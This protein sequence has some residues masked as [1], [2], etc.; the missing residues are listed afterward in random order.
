VWT[1]RLVNLEA[2]ARY[3]DLALAQLLGDAPEAHRIAAR[4]LTELA[5]VVAQQ[6]GGHSHSTVRPR[7]RHGAPRHAARTKPLLLALHV[8]ALAVVA[9]TTFMLTTWLSALK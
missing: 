4:L 5:G 7:E 1:V 9:S 2:R 8:F 3:L 6:G